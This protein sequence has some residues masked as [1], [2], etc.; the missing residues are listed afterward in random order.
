MEENEFISPYLYCIYAD[1]LTEMRC[2]EDAE[3]FYEIS[4]EAHPDDTI[5]LNN[6]AC[7]LTNIKQS[8]DKA[9]NLWGRCLE[10]DNHE[11]HHIKNFL[12]FYQVIRK[13]INKV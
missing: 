5:V 3:K 2:F 7:F 13:D 1:F 6:Y 9:E 11:Y 12:T 4:L 8:Y 10:L